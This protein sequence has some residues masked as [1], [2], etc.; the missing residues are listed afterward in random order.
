MSQEVNDTK[1]IDQ[2][3]LDYQKV[4]SEIG[5]KIIGQ[6]EV[7]KHLLICIFANGHCLLVGVP[8]LA[9]T[10]LVNSLASIMALSF[11][12]VQFT[13][14]LMPSDI[15]GSEIFSEDRKFQFNQGPVFANI[16]LAD[17]ND[18]G[19]SIYG[20]TASFSTDSVGLNDQLLHTFGRVITSISVN[21]NDP[22]HVVVGLGNIDYGQ[23][24]S[25]YI[26]ES[27]DALSSS[28]TFTAINGSGIVDAPVYSVEI[29][30][31]D[32]SIIYAGTEFGV[33]ATENGKG[34]G[35]STSWSYVG[36]EKVA[37]FAMEQVDL[38]G[39]LSTITGPSLFIGT[40][41]RGFFAHNFDP[42]VDRG[43]CVTSINDPETSVVK[44]QNITVY[45]NP[46]SDGG[47][48][49]IQLNLLK[50]SE[51]SYGIYALDGK[52]LDFVVPRKLSNGIH[53]L[54]LNAPGAK[55]IYIVKVLVG[56]QEYSS[57]LIRL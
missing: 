53:K 37:V 28:P 55:G 8:G 31:V 21:P 24:A 39:K 45:P 3:Y 17:I 10:L 32:G 23:T 49:F 14:D 6:D 42:C 46:L 12:R 16:V 47:D 51:V 41:G 52:Q 9:K 25:S 20:V 38:S 36:P 44:D 13:P 56:T 57:K 35:T 29:D 1:M 2:L 15:I 11:K 18:N 7:I 54:N 19:D 34:N 4:Q 48:A 22:N 30:M 33:Y 43:A 5:K 40:H 27:T 26:F 50:A